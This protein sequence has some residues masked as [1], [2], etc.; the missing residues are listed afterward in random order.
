MP[1]ILDSRMVNN[2]EIEAMTFKPNAERVRMVDGE[3]VTTYV[4][5]TTII[6]WLLDEDGN[7]LRRAVRRHDLFPLANSIT[8]L[9]F[10]N[11]L[12]L[13]Q[14]PAKA[15]AIADYNDFTVTE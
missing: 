8:S 5:L 10:I 3:E 14:P 12:N 6:Y 11:N 1:K 15:A 7:K 4:V 2:V 13:L 9:Q